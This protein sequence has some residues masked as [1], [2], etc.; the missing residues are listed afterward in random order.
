MAKIL[1]VDDDQHHIEMYQTKFQN[2]GYTVDVALDGVQGLLKIYE[3]RPDIILLDVL[4]PKVNG[5]DFLMKLKSNEK[6]KNIPVV[7]L[8]NVGGSDADIQKGLQLGAVAYLVKSKYTP[9]EILDKVA[10]ILA[11]Y[12]HNPPEEIPVVKTVINKPS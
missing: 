12:L 7:L 5:L 9:M 1:I 2:N 8:T 6:T 3:S 4:M 11:G 10:E